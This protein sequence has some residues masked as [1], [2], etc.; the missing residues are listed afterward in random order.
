M[1]KPRPVLGREGTENPFVGGS[2][3]VR[4]YIR[5]SFSIFSPIIF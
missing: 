1:G 5:G 4:G 3:A 2:I